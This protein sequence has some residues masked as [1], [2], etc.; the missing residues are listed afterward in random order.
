VGWAILSDFDGT[1]VEKDVAELVLQKFAEPGWERFNVLLADGKIN[2][3]ECVREEYALIRSR[4][5]HEVTEYARQ[6]SAF[7]SGFGELLQE[8]RSRDIDFAVVSAGLDFCIRDAFHVAKLKL[9]RLY[10][11]RSHFQLGKGIDLK[12]TKKRF[13]SAKDFKE[14]VVMAYK[15]RGLRVAYVGDG[16]GDINAAASADATFAIRSSVLDRMCRARKIR[17]R[18]IE[19]FVPVSKFLASAL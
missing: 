5:R 6:L 15:Q 11:P 10:C 19:S 7:R 1:I 13:P 14:D 4:T 18:A 9:P 16:A 12:F 3:E 2:V 8:C 17:Y